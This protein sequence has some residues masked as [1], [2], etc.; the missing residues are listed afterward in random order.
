VLAHHK[1]TSPERIVLLSGEMSVRYDGQEPERLR[2]GTYAYGPAGV[3]HAVTCLSRKPCVLFI[4]FVDP[5]DA[6]PVDH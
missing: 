4:A 6:I 1:H 2:P 5:V 3:P